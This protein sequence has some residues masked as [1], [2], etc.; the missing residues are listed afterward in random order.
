MFRFCQK[1]FPFRSF[2]LYRLSLRNVQKRVNSYPPRTLFNGILISNT[3]VFLLWQYSYYK[4]NVLGQSDLQRWLHKHFL[5]S[6]EAVTSGRPWTLLTSTFS[7]SSLTHFGFNMFV[8]Y[9]FAQQVKSIS[10]R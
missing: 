7:H 5:V 3:C 4:T 10:I 6:Y 8:F 1:H 9:N 2:S